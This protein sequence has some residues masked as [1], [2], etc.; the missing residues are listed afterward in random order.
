MM[1]A[2]SN[3]ESGEVASAGVPHPLRLG[4]T[5]LRLVPAIAGL[6]WM[7]ADRFSS[8]QVSFAQRD[9][10]VLEET[11][12]RRPYTK[13]AKALLCLELHPDL[14]TRRDE[15][16]VA[17]LQRGNQR[18]AARVCATN[19]ERV[20]SV[21]FNYRSVARQ[22]GFPPDYLTILT[23]FFDSLT[24]P[25]ERGRWRERIL[26]G[27]VGAPKLSTLLERKSVGTAQKLK[28]ALAALETELAGWNEVP[29]EDRKELRQHWARLLKALP[30]DLKSATKIEGEGNGSHQG[31]EPIEN[32][33]PLPRSTWLKPET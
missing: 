14:R 13:T 6:P 16:Q 4:P 10:L 20:G 28:R 8:V 3:A 32:P 17:G 1:E 2:Q 15:R 11:L 12:S 23:K 33:E 24:D 30:A 5:G 21:G 18:R 9:V 31:A 19:M 26:R 29:E 27:E 25:G 22:Y 7:S